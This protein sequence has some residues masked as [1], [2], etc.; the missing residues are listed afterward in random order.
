MSREKKRWLPANLTSVDR[1]KSCDVVF[2]GGEVETNVPMER[3]RLLYGLET[4]DGLPG[5]SDILAE[6]LAVEARY[7]G[8]FAVFYNSAAPNAV[9]TAASFAATV[10]IVVL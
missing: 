10:R 4:L 9:S 5:G 2:D 8:K 6:G 3:I 7:K 1:D